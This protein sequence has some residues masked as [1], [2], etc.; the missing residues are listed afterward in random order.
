MPH[1]GRRETLNNRPCRI[2]SSSVRSI[3]LV[4]ASGHSQLKQREEN[5]SS[6]LFQTHFSA[7]SFTASSCCCDSSFAASS[8][9]ALIA[10]SDADAP[11]STSSSSRLALMSRFCVFVRGAVACTLAAVTHACRW[12]QSTAVIRLCPCVWRGECLSKGG[13]NY[14][15]VFTM[16]SVCRL[17][18]SCLAMKTPLGPSYL[19]ATGGVRV[20]LVQ[21]ARWNI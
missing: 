19:L 2:S 20:D 12:C 4:V 21:R 15:G 6:V 11:F 13:P 5:R 9:S 17:K 7:A 1:L 3:A 18:P 8:L 14:I 10:A 16:M